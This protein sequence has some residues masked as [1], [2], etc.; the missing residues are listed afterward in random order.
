MGTLNSAMNAMMDGPPSQQEGA[1]GNRATPPQRA[2]D[3]LMMQQQQQKQALAFPLG[4][5]QNEQPPQMAAQQQSPNAS[6]F[7]QAV[8]GRGPTG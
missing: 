4:V 6:S 7:M 5:P 3:K 2:I 1:L 8:L